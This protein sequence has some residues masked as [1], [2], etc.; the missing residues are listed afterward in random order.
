MAG[1][2]IG[3]F[4]DTFLPT[5]NGVTYTVTT[6]RDRWIANGG[7][8][9]IVYPAVDGYRPAADEYPIRSLPF[10]FYDGYRVAVPF[11]PDALGEVDVI[12]AHTP[13]SLGLA[14]LRYRRRVDAPLVASYHTPT[15]EYTSYLAPFI[16][17]A[18]WLS[19]ISQRYERWFYDQADI[20]TVPTKVTADRLRETLEVDTPIRI[21]SNGVD[22]DRFR[23]VDPG[24]FLDQYDLPNGPLI[25]YT[26]RHGHEKCLDA[27]VDAVAAGPDDWTLVLAGGGPATDGLRT[28]AAEGGIDA[29][30]L[31]FLDRSDLPAF[32]T[33]IDVFAFP[34]P[35][36]TQGLV[37][38]ESI[39][40]GTPVVGIDSGA[41]SE[42]IEQGETGFLYPADDIP[43][44][45][46]AITRALTD[47]ERLRE[48]CLD[49]RSDHSVADSIAALSRIYRDCR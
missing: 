27:L 34:S 9:P 5:V 32:Y 15:G 39:A 42:T 1:G 18:K 7:E 10:P 45:T 33:A 11:I 31:G 6:W 46:A 23:P 21:V 44:F 38:L 29:R 25:G 4:T 36:E 3:T 24:R 13:F 49:R 2:R 43:A 8:M 12:H 14:A 40:C 48:I 35:V 41:L 17:V 22:L 28:R 37:A 30:F 26:G 47:A 19:A 20:V 16:P